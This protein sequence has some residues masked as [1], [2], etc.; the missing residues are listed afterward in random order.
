MSALHIPGTWEHR[1]FR[2]PGSAQTCGLVREMRSR[3][4][5]SSAW[6]IAVYS[7]I[8]EVSIY[9]AKIAD[10]YCYVLDVDLVI[11]PSPALLCCILNPDAPFLVLRLAW[12]TGIAVD[13]ETPAQLGQ[14]DG[15][16]RALA[17]LLECLCTDV[18]NRVQVESGTTN[19]LQH[20]LNINA[21]CICTGTSL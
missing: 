8:I 12:T 9:T 18:C 13:A 16:V 5:L 20:T 17:T 19:V 21:L 7:Q 1:S 11:W 6:N 15:L 14:R 3:G 2:G 10:I 4:L